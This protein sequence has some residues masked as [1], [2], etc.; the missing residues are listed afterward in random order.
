[1]TYVMPAPIRQR[2]EQ[3]AHTLQ[4][5]LGPKLVSL[6]VFGSAARGGYEEGRSD[7]DLVLVLK[8]SAPEVLL[9]IANTLTVARTALRFET[10]ILK[11]DEIARAADVFP[12]FYD[13]IRSCHLLLAGK[14]VFA[15]LPISDAH[16]RVR[17]EQELRECQI[18][19]RR[20]V[21]DSM[22]APQALAGAIERKVKQIRSPMHALLHLR[23]T[24]PLD[25][26]LE[27][28]LAKARDE[29]MVDIKYLS[30]ARKNP[31]KALE[32]FNTLLTRMIEEVDRMEA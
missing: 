20:V 15:N 29:W 2:L 1:M 23:K 22:G 24:P 19:M 10:V 18:R 17:I 32:V 12:L 5:Q 26:K 27:T 7:V 9:A 4:V 14:D 16:R 11:E 8:D 21:V 3:L 31:T 25:D 30:Q 13:D 28:V 6:L